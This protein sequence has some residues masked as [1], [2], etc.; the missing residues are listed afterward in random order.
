LIS[1]LRPAPSPTGALQQTEA[2]WL[3]MS[4]TG[5]RSTLVPAQNLFDHAALRRFDK[6]HHGHLAPTLR[7]GQWVHFVHSLDQHRPTLTTATWRRFRR[8]DRAHPALE[9][10]AKATK[11][12]DLL[13]GN[14][15][16]E[17]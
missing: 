13:M 1:T 8:V 17:E 2:I 14:R 9:I 6:G 16:R 4:A 3:P 5:H 12:L 10:A 11:I 15:S 7:T